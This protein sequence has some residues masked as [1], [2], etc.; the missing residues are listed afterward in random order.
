MDN[1]GVIIG[2]FQIDTL[3]EGH[4][5]LINHALQSHHKVIVFIGCS[6]RPY[7]QNNPLD[8]PTRERMV[9]AAFPDVVV[10]PLRDMASDVEWSQQV[11]D[12][13]SVV[14]PKGNAILYGGR[15][16]FVPHYKGIHKPMEIDSP[17]SYQSGTQKRL[18]IGKVVRSSPDFRA[19]G[20][21]QSQ[22]SPIRPIMGVDIAV[23]SYHGDR[24]NAAILMGRKTWDKE[25]LW[26]LPGGKVEPD[27]KSLEFAARRELLEETDASVEGK[28]TYLGS[29]KISDWRDKGQRDLTY[30]SAL[31]MGEY[32]FGSTCAPSSD[33]A[34]LTFMA[35]NS[36]I[37]SKTVPEHRCLIEMVVDQ[38]KKDGVNCG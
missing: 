3:H 4:M 11:D 16:S 30:F 17:I 27:D 10:M 2:R 5:F 9:R 24:T 26:R 22:N 7:S 32:T 21:Y 29:N 15:D 20:I 34:V 35:V 33:L 38:L 25:G 28:L 6:I 23:I 12:L 36:S 1:T 31:F 8:Y 19:G 37:L 18:E 13:I 14:S